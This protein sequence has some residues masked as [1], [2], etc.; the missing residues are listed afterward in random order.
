MQHKSRPKMK[1]CPSTPVHRSPSPGITASM[2]LGICSIFLGSL[3]ILTC[4]VILIAMPLAGLG[5]LLGLMSL[6]MTS[7][8]SW[9]GIT[10]L[11]LSLLGVL[12]PMVVLV[13]FVIADQ[14][15]EEEWNRD[16]RTVVVPLAP[17]KACM[18]DSIYL[19]GDEE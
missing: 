7:D 19:L 11:G 14:P 1:P 17:E 2:T 5:I 15:V 4:C 13:L 10:G 18:T 6:A 8:R 12:L 3:S 9:L 16:N